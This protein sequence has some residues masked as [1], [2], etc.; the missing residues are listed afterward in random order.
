MCL[1]LV[2]CHASATIPPG[3]HSNARPK[4][5]NQCSCGHTTHVH[6]KKTHAP[7]GKFTWITEAG[8]KERWVVANVGNFSVIWNLA[9]VRA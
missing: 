6:T 9:K 5:Q 3:T 8:Q 7:A 1:Q 4:A 2:L